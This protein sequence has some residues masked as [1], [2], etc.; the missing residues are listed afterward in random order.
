MEHKSLSL[1]FDTE[2]PYGTQADTPEQ[3]AFRKRQLDFISKMNSTFDV[4]QIP[5]THFILTD[6]LQRCADAVGEEILRSLYRKNHPL[7]ELQ[8]HSHSHPV[9][10]TLQGVAKE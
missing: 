1:G 2:R 7:Q 9:M 8:Q 5:R 6:Y 10:D 3:G 4:A